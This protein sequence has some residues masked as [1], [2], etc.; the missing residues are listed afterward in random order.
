[1]ELNA[2]C[3]DPGLSQASGPIQLLR[4]YGQLVIS[5]WSWPAMAVQQP[6]HFPS[7]LTTASWFP[8]CMI[9]LSWSTYKEN[10]LLTPK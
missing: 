1:M 9:L 6:R 5:C 3:F 2:E 8:L 4:A 7:H 10:L